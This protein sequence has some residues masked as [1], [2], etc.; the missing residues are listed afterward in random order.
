MLIDNSMSKQERFDFFYNQMLQDDKIIYAGKMLQKAYEKFPRNIALI[1][2]DREI[3]YTELYLYAC[4]FSEKLKKNGV[5][6]GDRVLIF[7]RNSFEFYV[8][9]FGAW[10]VGAV[11]APL[12]I[13]LKEKELAHIVRD[14]QAKLAVVDFQKL[15]LFKGFGIA[16]FTQKDLELDHEFD[17]ASSKE[18]ENFEIPSRDSE[19]M[20]ALLYTS[21]TTGLPKGVMLSSKNIMTNVAQAF[22][23]MPFAESK[24]IFCI[25]PLFHCFAQNT[26]VWSALCA[27]CAVIVVPKITRKEI[28]RG[29]KHKPDIFLGVPALYGLLC[30][31]KT[32]PLE[33]VEYFVSGGDALPD[34]IRAG[35]ALVY[36]RK[37][38]N[39]YGLTETSPLISVDFEDVTVPTSN[40]GKPVIGI[41]CV[42]KG[43]DGTVLSQGQIGELLIKG[44]NVMVGYYNEPQ[45][46]KEVLKDGWLITGDLAKFDENGKLIICGRLK[47]V[48]IHK[49]MNIYPQEIENV[50]LKHRAVLQV[51][52]I[53]KNDN[54]YGQVPIAV[55][56]LRVKH[57]FIEDQLRNLCVTELAAY[58]VP[59]K[60]IVVKDMP[61]T[62]TGKI[63]KISLKKQIFR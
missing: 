22:S 32:V 35:F 44:D 19:Q 59:R 36:G 33:S 55:I 42:I 2:Q 57:E 41:E 9:Y 60:F 50:I 21:G 58:K 5:E 52:V 53:G 29:L 20:A 17:L 54:S 47:D 39:G 30:L 51:G 12:N 31:L 4:R 8:A 48:I 62:A 27:G 11:V 45:K 40:V 38:C 1:C 16:L 56:K 3:T 6:S 63:D 18:Y 61:L 24:R 13:F 25:L 7:F 14:S 46:T 28:M 37:L 43:Q 49:G 23:I 10:Q 15:D 34:K 26:C